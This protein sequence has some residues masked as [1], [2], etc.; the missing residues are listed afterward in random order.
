MYSLLYIIQCIHYYTLYNVYII[1]HYTMYN[2][3]NVSGCWLIVGHST[4]FHPGRVILT[5][6]LLK[7]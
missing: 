4:P 5:S 6:S 1:I 3:K 7:V 2:K